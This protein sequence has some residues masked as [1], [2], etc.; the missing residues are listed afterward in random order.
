MKERNHI[1]IAE[2]AVAV[3]ALVG[4]TVS[5]ILGQVSS[6]ALVGLYGTVLGYVFGRVRS[7]IEQ[8]AEV[9]GIQL[10]KKDPD[11]ADAIVE[12]SRP[13][14]DVS[15]HTVPGTRPEK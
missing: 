6:D 15:E 13:V 10:A 8:R 4:A 2:G 3:V 12:A 11:V 5:A 9:Q 7:G 14:E 1:G